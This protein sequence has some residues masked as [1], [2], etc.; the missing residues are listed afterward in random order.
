MIRQGVVFHA[1]ALAVTLVLSPFAR[2]D[3][4]NVILLMLD[5]VRWQEVFYGAD[6]DLANGEQGPAFPRLWSELV[7]HGI[8]YGDRNKGEM[9]LTSNSSYLSLPGYQS[10]FAGWPQPCNSNS[11]GRVG[12]ETLQERLAREYRVGLGSAAT[13]ASWEQIPN[14]VEHVEGSTFVNAARTKL[15]DGTNDEIFDRIN[16]AQAQDPPPWE[17]SR[18][19]KYTWAHSMR[20]LEKHRPRFMFIS[21]NDSD[22]WG[23]KGNYAAYFKTLRQYD[24]WI[25][26]LVSRLAMMGEYGSNTTVIITTDHGRGGGSS[27]KFHGWFWPS[28][29]Y[30]WMF[31]IGPRVHRRAE[32]SDVRYTHSDIRPTI[33]ALL[34]LRPF[35][36]RE[37]GTPIEEIAGGRGREF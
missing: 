9:M 31:A 10:V 22:E 15:S 7:P 36:C 35:Q 32:L 29:K 17:G 23:H 37:C 21:L 20:Y 3:E 24:Q 12:V 4:G 8:I 26:E 19:D 33:E 14:A 13:V 30:I 25:S 27:W 2:A 11:C 5:G 6:K 1:L 28:S 16:D 18:W 34:G